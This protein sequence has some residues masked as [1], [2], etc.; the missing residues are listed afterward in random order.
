MAQFTIYSSGDPSAPSLT[1]EVGSLVN[2][3]DKCLVAGYGAKTGAGWTKPY[4]GANKAAFKQG[5]NSCGFYLRVNDAPAGA[6]GAR[7]AHIT[8]Y[9]SMTDVDTGT[10][11]FPNATQGLAGTSSNYVVRKSDA[12]S[13][14]AR[15]W[16]LFADSRTC[17]FITT[18]SGV[19]TS[20]NGTMFFGDFFSLYPGVTD[21][22]RCITGGSLTEGTGAINQQFQTPL[23]GIATDTTWAMPNSA[24][25]FVVARP[26]SG[27]GSST[28]ITPIGDGI[29]G[30]LLGSCVGT[31]QCPN[32]PDSGF[33]LSPIWVGSPTPRQLRGRFRGI[34]QW[35][36]PVGTIGTGDVF[37]GT[38]PQAGKTFVAV[39]N[40]GSMMIFETSD[41]LDTNV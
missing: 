25:L 17:Y 4:T 20:Y 27:V 36:H 32:S 41:T 31:M 38:G 35:L 7:E 6:G 28:P 21:A 26:G 40:G 22:W 24:N 34:Y 30:A 37:S 12:A 39:R 8:G 33:Y 15:G 14:V 13:A 18:S 10:G 5:A 1:G 9:E 2:V 16:L 3:L 11:S 19:D 23:M 29:R